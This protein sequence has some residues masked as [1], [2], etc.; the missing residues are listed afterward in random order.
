MKEQWIDLNPYL[1]ELKSIALSRDVQKG[2]YVSTKN[3]SVGKSTHFVGVC[4]EKCVSLRTGLP[5]DSELRVDGDPGYD[6]VHNGITYDVKTSTFF[7]SPDLK[8]FVSPKKWS[9]VCILVAIRSLRW[10]KVIGWATKAQLLSSSRRN[11]GHG[12]ML[13]FTWR[14]LEKMGQSGLPKMLPVLPIPELTASQ[15]DELISSS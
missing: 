7:T 12:D 14:E 5:I 2:G 10:S 13:T 11:Y 3:W 4:G 6:F 15:I 1:E 8:E 9:D